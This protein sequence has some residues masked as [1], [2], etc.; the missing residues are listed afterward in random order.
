[1]I[2]KILKELTDERIEKEISYVYQLDLPDNAE[3]WVKSYEKIGGRNEFIWKWLFVT[4]SEFYLPVF[5]KKHKNSLL[6]VKFLWTM[7][8]VL[9]DDVAD[10]DQNKK[11]LNNLIKIPLRQENKEELKKLSKKDKKYFDFAKNIWEE[12]HKI[13]S[14]F[15]NYK[16]LKEILYYDIKQVLNVMEYSLL[17]NKNPILINKAEANLFFPYNMSLFVYSDFDLLCSN[18]K[19]LG[20]VGIIRELVFKMQRIARIGNW[21]STWEREVGEKDFSSGVFIYALDRGFVKIEDLEKEKDEVVIRKIKKS[22]AEEEMFEEWE[23]NYKEIKKISKD[24][25]IIDRKK[26]IS[27]CEKLLILH[28]SS[29]NYK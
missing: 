23:S 28:L 11:L 4:F 5:S 2:E 24:I 10:K 18:S 3:K 14:E 25:D 8:V 20:Y 21:V 1:M 17:I 26:L 19:S 6:L 15:P 27:S 9:L 16:N 7:F 13:I 12:I 29:K 22:K